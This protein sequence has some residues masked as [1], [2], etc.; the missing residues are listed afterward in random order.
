MN[1]DRALQIS[2]FLLRVVPGFM[3]IQVGGLKLFGWFGG[4][5]PNHVA[6][7]FMTQLWIG[8]ALEVVG[9][10]LI[11]LGLF[12][13]PVAFILSGEMAVAYFQFHQPG[14]TWPVQNHGEPAVLMCFIFLYMAARGA[15]DWS[16][17][18]LL[19]RKPGVDDAG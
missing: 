1:R 2:Y 16:L 17:D 12:T 19:G 18:A 11:L 7:T 6:A 9:G 13:R 4:M 3:F 15:G 8:G 14:G 5:P 10:L